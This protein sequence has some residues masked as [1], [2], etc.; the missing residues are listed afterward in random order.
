MATTLSLTM[1]PL[2][3]ARFEGIPLKDRREPRGG[4][5]SGPSSWRRPRGDMCGKP[6]GTRLLF[7]EGVFDAANRVLDLAF[8]LLGLAIGLELG[9]ADYLAGRFLNPAYDLF[10]R[11]CDPVFVQDIVLSLSV[12]G[13][14]GAPTSN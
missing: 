5:S 2:L 8:D 10:C 3:N 1:Q 11:S 4:T 7:L 6:G 13:K 12:A 9:V 14:G